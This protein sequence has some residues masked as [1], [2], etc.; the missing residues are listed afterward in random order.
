MLLGVIGLTCTCDNHVYESN[1]ESGFASCASTTCR[2]HSDQIAYFD[3]YPASNAPEFNSNWNNYR[4]QRLVI[5]SSIDGACQ[6]RPRLRAPPAPRHWPQ[7]P[8]HFRID[9]S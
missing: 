1:Y 9:L 3:T 4:R 7:A 8:R 2:R 5:A 6:L